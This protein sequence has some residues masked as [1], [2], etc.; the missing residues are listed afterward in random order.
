MAGR[1][2]LTVYSGMSGM[3]ENAFINVKNQS[4]TIT[5]DIVVPEGSADGVS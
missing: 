1:K 2:T 5:A 3:S 4:H